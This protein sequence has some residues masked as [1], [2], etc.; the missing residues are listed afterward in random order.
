LGTGYAVVYD[1]YDTGT[2][3]IHA[4]GCDGLLFNAAR[5][6]LWP[7]PVRL[8]GGR[9]SFELEVGLHYASHSLPADGTDLSFSVIPGFEWSSA[10]DDKRTWVAGVRWMH[11]S[12]GGLFGRNGGYDGLIIRLGRRWSR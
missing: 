1:D 9:V 5:Q 2:N 4:R 10:P 3:T 12:H 11:V 6:T 7:L 8:A